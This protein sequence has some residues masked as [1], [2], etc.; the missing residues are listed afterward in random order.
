MSTRT[1]D[2]TLR[3]R[4]GVTHRT[5]VARILRAWDAATERDREAGRT[6]Y[7]DAAE[8]ASELAP[9]AGSVEH[10]ATVIAH[11]SPRTSWA[12]NVAGARGLVYHGMA[13]HCMPA[14]VDRARNA[15]ASKTPVATLNGPKVRRFAQN[16]LGDTDAV[17]VDVWAARVAL[18]TPPDADRILARKGVYD[19]L[20]DAYRVAARRRGVAPSVMQA[21]TWVVARN[22][23]AA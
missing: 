5:V 14:N 20:E 16:I 22:G 9:Y 6:W 21:T 1:H 8:V 17:T 10:A 3:R 15:L 19:A 2:A 11:L 12:R 7:A 18:A 4:A 13:E 23:R